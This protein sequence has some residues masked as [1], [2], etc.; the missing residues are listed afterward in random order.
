METKNLSDSQFQKATGVKIATFS[1]NGISHGSP[2]AISA[3]QQRQA[4]FLGAEDRLLIMLIYCS[5]YRTFYIS[6]LSMKLAKSGGGTLFVKWK[7]FL[8]T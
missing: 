2:S 3:A 4:K 8:L 6:V 5:E 7:T 1:Q